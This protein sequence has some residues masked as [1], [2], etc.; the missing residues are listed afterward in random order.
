LSILAALRGFL[1][2]VLPPGTAVFPARINRIPEPQGADFVMM[3]VFRFERLRTNV[4]TYQDCSF[5]GSID[6]ETMT[7]TEVRQG[8]ILA[9]A[10]VF[11]IGVTVGTQVVSQ[12]SGITGAGGTYLVSQPSQEVGPAVLASGAKLLE[13]GARCVVQ[14]DFHSANDSDAADMAQLV[15]TLFRDE[16]AVDWFAAESPNYGEYRVAPLFADDP[17]SM[18]WVNEN[19]QYEWRYVVECHLQVNQVAVVPQ[20][21]MDV[22]TVVPKSVYAQFPPQ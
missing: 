20:Q 15:A 19:Q 18:P 13:Q 4:D 9:G 2:Q 12:S 22:V 16:Y 1:I 7:V 5:V 6:G 14:L 3:N 17:R 10:M 8:T 11:G 21:F